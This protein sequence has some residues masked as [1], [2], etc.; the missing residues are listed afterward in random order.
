MQGHWLDC[1]KD[2]TQIRRGVER[3]EKT[4]GDGDEA[5]SRYNTDMS[6]RST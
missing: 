2:K 6:F 3:M 4:A 5:R 1:R